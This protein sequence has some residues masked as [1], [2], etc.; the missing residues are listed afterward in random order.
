[1]SMTRNDYGSAKTP[2]GNNTVMKFIDALNAPYSVQAIMGAGVSTPRRE[3]VI[4]LA[5]LPEDYVVGQRV[6]YGNKIGVIKTITDNVDDFVSMVVQ[7]EKPGAAPY[8]VTFTEQA[9]YDS[10]I[11]GIS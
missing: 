10:T 11:V 6:L 3:S 9:L 8:D 7:F 4:P 1:M 5:T 2:S